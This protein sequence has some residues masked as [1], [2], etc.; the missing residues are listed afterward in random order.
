MP[1]TG[2]MRPSPSRPAPALP[3]GCCGAVDPI[4]GR[5]RSTALPDGS[6]EA[7]IFEQRPGSRPAAVTT[8]GGTTRLRWGDASL[9]LDAV[10]PAAGWAGRTDPDEDDADNDVTVSFSRGG[11]AWEVVVLRAAMTD[12]RAFVQRTHR[13]T[14]DL[15]A[16]VDIAP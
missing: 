7:A 10:E 1:T 9:Y 6:W 3:C 4:N 16:S 15:G 12:G 8:P 5:S 11:E 13:W 2:R 14:L